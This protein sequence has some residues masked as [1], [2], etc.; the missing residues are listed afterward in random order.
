[1][2]KLETYIDNIIEHF[3][4]E[5]AVV[6]N[7]FSRGDLTKDEFLTAVNKYIKTLKVSEELHTQILKRYTDYLWAYDILEPL[8]QAEDITDL[9]CYSL[10]NI[11]VY[12]IIGYSQ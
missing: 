4:G 8:I 11:C 9:Q 7:A 5:E 10:N 2:E 3:S 1:M 12:H 6:M